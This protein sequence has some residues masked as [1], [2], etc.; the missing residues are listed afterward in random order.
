MTTDGFYP[1][2]SLAKEH[3]SGDDPLTALDYIEFA[4]YNAG[5]E[6]DLSV[7]VEAKDG[8]RTR[9]KIFGTYRLASGWNI[10]R[11]TGF[12]NYSWKVNGKEMAENVTALRLR[13]ARR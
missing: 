8:A 1:H 11:V 3:I 13:A 10:I 12:A 5:E 9:N 7:Y 2:L 6:F 4:I